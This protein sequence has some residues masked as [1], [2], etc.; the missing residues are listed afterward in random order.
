MKRTLLLSFMGSFGLLAYACSSS[1]SNPNPTPQPEAGTSSGTDTGTSGSSGTDTGTSSG[2]PDT[3]LPD[4]GP[5]DNPI[6]GIAAATVV[7]PFTATQYLEGPIWVGTALYVT[8]YAP[9][10]GGT[11]IQFTPGAADPTKQVRQAAVG[12]S[13]IGNTYDTKNTTLVS[14]EITDNTQS[15]AIVRTPA[16][17]PGV[18]T[19]I[20]ITTE[21]GPGPAFDAPNDVV[22]NSKGVMY[23]TDPGYQNPGTVNNHIWRITPGATALV[24]DAVETVSSNRP[25][26]IA[27]SPDE[28]TLYVSYSDTPSKIDKFA[29][30]ATTGAIGAST[31][32]V[33]SL[34]PSTEAD[35][36][37]VDT[38]GNVYCAVKDGV[39]V[40]KKDGTK[41]G[42]IPTISG[43]QINGLA[44]GGADKKTLY[45]TCN[46]PNG[47]LLS[48]K[49]NIAG[50]TQ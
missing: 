20:A 26:G 33:A 35:G 38:A 22:V 14:V 31:P 30:D 50:L 43:K 19:P 3:G 37:A 46:A 16:T 11:L 25:N 18:G 44:F 27:L 21:A 42:K 32:F 4:T 34:A 13:M 9:A 39:E 8:E 24:A 28:K 47:G 5:T 2:I 12:S 1:D 40:F 10:T 36:L 6:Q 41:W 29:L 15:G 7:A 17:A 48:V 45:M 23:V 49:V